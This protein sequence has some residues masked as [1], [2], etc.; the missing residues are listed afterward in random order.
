MV[1]STT[2][3]MFDIVGPRFSTHLAR[4]HSIPISRKNFL[5][6]LFNLDFILGLHKYFVNSIILDYFL[7]GSHRKLLCPISLIV[8]YI[9]LNLDFDLMYNKSTKIKLI[10][11]TNRDESCETLQTA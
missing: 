3:K 11:A 10:N 6:F 5:N 1:A 4:E 8:I 7:K 2:R 9:G